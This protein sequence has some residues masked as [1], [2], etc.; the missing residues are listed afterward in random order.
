MGISAAFRDPSAQFAP[1]G[2]RVLK[3][4]H[5]DPHEG[6]VRLD[7]SDDLQR[8]IV[9]WSEVRSLGFD[10]SMHAKRLVTTC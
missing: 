7:T 5:A 3:P 4:I 8:R 10:R 2:L 9:R 6:L 1:L